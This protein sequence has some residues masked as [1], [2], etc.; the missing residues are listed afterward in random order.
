M[1][2][3]PETKFRPD[4]R[5]ELKCYSCGHQGHVARDCLDVLTEA[6]HKIDLSSALVNCTKQ[7]MKGIELMM[8]DKALMTEKRQSEVGKERTRKY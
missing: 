1:Q 2:D 7:T 5:Q 3:C 8:N 6:I 4:R